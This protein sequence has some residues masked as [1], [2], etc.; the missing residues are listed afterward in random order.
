MH[1]DPGSIDHLRFVCDKEKPAQCN[2]QE[3]SRHMDHPVQSLCEW[4]DIHNI[5]VMIQV[6]FIIAIWSKSVSE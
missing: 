5:S 2:I 6:Q 1:H 4:S 3:T